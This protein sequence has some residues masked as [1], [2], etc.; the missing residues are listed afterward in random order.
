[1]GL[2]DMRSFHEA[3]AEQVNARIKDSAAQGDAMMQMF[4]SS[5][6]EPWQAFGRLMAGGNTNQDK[7]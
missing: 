4:F 6:M 1:M 3:M 2:P 5:A 7:P